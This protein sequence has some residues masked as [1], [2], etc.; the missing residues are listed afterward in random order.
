MEPHNSSVQRVGFY[1]MLAL[2]TVAFCVLLLPFY[3]AILWAIILAIIFHPVQKY[4]VRRLKGR[5]NAAALL[6][7]LM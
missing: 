4:L 6:N 1:L 2:T 3:T 7:V 5:Q